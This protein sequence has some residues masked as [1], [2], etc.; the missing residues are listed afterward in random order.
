MRNGIGTVWE[1]EQEMYEKRNWKHIGKRNRKCMRKG[2]GNV[3]E[4][5]IGNVCEK[6]QEMYETKE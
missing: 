2:I 1:K 4:N 3:C 5:G 6:E